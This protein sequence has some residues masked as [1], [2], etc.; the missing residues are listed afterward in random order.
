V[1]LSGFRRVLVVLLCAVGIL[2][3]WAASASGEATVDTCPMLTTWNF[4]PALNTSSHS[5]NIAASY[6]GSCAGVLVDSNDPFIWQTVFPSTWDNSYF[7]GYSYFGS[8]ELA[9]MS[10]Y[11]SWGSGEIIGGSVVYAIAS[12]P[13]YSPGYLTEV[14]ILTPL[15]PC[16]EVSAIGYSQASFVGEF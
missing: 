13:Y 14:T 12:N 16:S 2:A 1:G 9:T 7:G 6:S 4:S 5:G 10:Y 11:G 15:L 3:P 8:C